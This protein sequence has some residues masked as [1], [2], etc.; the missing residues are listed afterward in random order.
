M[1]QCVVLLLITLHGPH[2]RQSPCQNHF[3]RKQDF[4]V[5][6]TEKCC[7]ACRSTQS[8]YI[9]RLKPPDHRVRWWLK[10]ALPRQTFAPAKLFACA[11]CFPNARITPKMII[12]RHFPMQM[13]MY[14]GK[15]RRPS[16]P[17][18][19][20]IRIR[21]LNSIF[22]VEYFTWKMLTKTFAFQSNSSQGFPQ[23]T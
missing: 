6:A 1:L 3:G 21:K 2:A 4:C 14:P 15:Q 19:N 23:R 5:D 22:I 13:Q 10:T 18:T 11:G 7:P 16:P 17:I 8:Q 9:R 12:T 20:T